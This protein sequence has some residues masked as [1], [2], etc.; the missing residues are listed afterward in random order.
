MWWGELNAWTQRDQL[1]LCYVAW[2][3]QFKI[4][5]IS[6]NPRFENDY[7]KWHPHKETEKRLLYRL[8][9]KLKFYG[10]WILFYPNFTLKI[11]LMGKPHLK[12]LV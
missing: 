3:Q 8:I 10:R 2:K 9:R 1:S 6:E 5:F 11:G 12:K 4:D 7:F